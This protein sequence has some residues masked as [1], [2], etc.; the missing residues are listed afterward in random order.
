MKVVQLT[1][2]GDYSSHYLIDDHQ[3]WEREIKMH[4]GLSLERLHYND[5]PK[6]VPGPGEVLVEIHGC[7]LNHTADPN[8]E[9]RA[10]TWLAS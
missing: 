6:P 2:S 5:V 10:P 8:P 1:T 7:G 3:Q 4:E 9:P